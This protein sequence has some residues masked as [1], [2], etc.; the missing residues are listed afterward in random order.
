MKS[1]GVPG[2]FL[3]TRA[4]AFLSFTLRTDALLSNLKPQFAGGKCE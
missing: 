3:L 1:G 2:R 4:D